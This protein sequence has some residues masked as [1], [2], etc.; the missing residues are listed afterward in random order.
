MI[1]LNGCQ[2]KQNNKLHRPTLTLIGRRGLNY[3]KED[4]ELNGHLN[5]QNRI[6]VL[7]LNKRGVESHLLVDS[8]F[9]DTI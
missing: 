2:M 4:S 5:R 8:S 9:P 3:G 6:P 1:A 7:I